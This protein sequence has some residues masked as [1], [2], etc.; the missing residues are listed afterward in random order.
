M[1]A[2]EEEEE[3]E[4]GGKHLQPLRCERRFFG[5]RLWVALAVFVLALGLR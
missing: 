2:G 1:G 5:S 4:E 3:E